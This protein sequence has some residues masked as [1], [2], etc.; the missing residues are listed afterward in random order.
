MEDLNS[1]VEVRDRMRAEMKR[2]LDNCEKLTQKIERDREVI[3]SLS[4]AL[5]AA[6]LESKPR[7]FSNVVIS[8]KLGKTVLK[9]KATVDDVVGILRE[10]D[11]QMDTGQL[12]REFQ[13]RGFT[14]H[15]DRPRASF[16]AYLNN[17]AAT[18]NPILKKLGKNG[19]GRIEW[20]LAEWRTKEELG[21]GKEVHP[22]PSRQPISI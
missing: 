6:G 16:T 15:G 9:G 19:L 13:K 3:D 10:T 14:S 18:K 20:G 4:A 11:S 7:A 1:V 2:D 8:R 21:T 5:Q 17:N 12:W 22:L